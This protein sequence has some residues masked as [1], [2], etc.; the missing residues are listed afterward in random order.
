MCSGYVKLLMQERA[1]GL[2]SGE[3]LMEVSAV[4]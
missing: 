4:C 1:C 2:V 3:V